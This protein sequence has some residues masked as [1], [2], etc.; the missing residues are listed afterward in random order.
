MRETNTIASKSGDLSISEK[1]ILIKVE[2]EKMREQVQ[3][4]E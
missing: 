3:N 2:I 1:A 4:V